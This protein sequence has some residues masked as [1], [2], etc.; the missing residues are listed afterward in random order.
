MTRSDAQGALEAAS[1]TV[2]QHWGKGSDAKTTA[3]AIL[4]KK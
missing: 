2:S 3:Q 1:F 4:D